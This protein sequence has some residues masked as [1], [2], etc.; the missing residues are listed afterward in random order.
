MGHTLEEVKELRKSKTIL[1]MAAA[2]VAGGAG[3]ASLMGIIDHLKRLNTI[4]HNKE[5]Q[6]DKTRRLAQANPID[7]GMTGKE[8]VVNPTAVTAAA[9]S[10]VVSL[11][12]VKKLITQALLSND[13]KALNELKSRYTGKLKERSDLLTSKQAADNDGDGRSFT[14]GE[15]ALSSAAALP[16]LI[17]LGTAIATNQYLKHLDPVAAHKKKEQ[18]EGSNLDALK[19][20]EDKLASFTLPVVLTLQLKAARSGPLGDLV[21]TV[22]EGNGR[23]LAQAMIIDPTATLDSIQGAHKILEGLDETELTKAA[24]A[25][26]ATPSLAPVTM[27][28]VKAE[29]EEHFPFITKVA[30]T[31]SDEDKEEIQAKVMD[32]LLEGREPSGNT[33]EKDEVQF[34]ETGEAS[35]DE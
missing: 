30:A 25:V 18:E 10:G 29:M 12:V 26:W 13:K 34:V 24:S 5:E 33:K 9:V 23:K 22:I 17:A 1:N 28:Y 31:M 35:D 2:G 3:L 21:G 14:Q 20:M 11:V 6:A 4:K 15:G 19:L 16:I 7:R 8:A 27:L 32:K